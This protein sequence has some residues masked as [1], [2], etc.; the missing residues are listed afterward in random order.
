VPIGAAAL[1]A[2]QAYIYRYR[3]L[4]ERERK[5]DF[6]F[7]NKNGTP[8]TRQGFWK[9]LKK[10]SASSG[11]GKNIYPHIFRHSFAT[12]M[13]EEG[14]D[15]RIV[16]ELLGHASISTTEIYTDVSKKHL[17]ASYFRFHPMETKSKAGHRDTAAKSSTDNG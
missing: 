5:H 9:I 12:H 14:A 3:S 13:L 7:L 2:V 8:L 16:Q 10:Y 1:E 11:T 6:V 15:L 17:K 4:L